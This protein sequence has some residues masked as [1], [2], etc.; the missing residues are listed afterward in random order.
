MKKKRR[1]NANFVSSC[2]VLSMRNDAREQT[3]L[4]FMYLRNEKKRMPSDERK[5]KSQM[6]ERKEIRYHSVVMEEQKKKVQRAHTHKSE[7]ANETHNNQ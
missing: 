3:Y 2:G 7:A 6:I 4:L 1:S 5:M